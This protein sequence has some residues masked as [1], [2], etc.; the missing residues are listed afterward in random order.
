MSSLQGKSVVDALAYSKARVGQLEREAVEEKDE[1]QRTEQTL[2]EGERKFQ[3]L[4]DAMPQIVWTA[5]PDG[6]FDYYNRR[7]YDFTG[8]P[9]GVGGDESW[10]DVVHPDDQKE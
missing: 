9:E 1:R 5:G 3:E 2:R 8:R 4:A 6:H 7:W 10:T